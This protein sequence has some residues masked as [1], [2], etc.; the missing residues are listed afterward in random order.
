MMDAMGNHHRD[1]RGQSVEALLEV[2]PHGRHL[3]EAASAMSCRMSSSR[4]LLVYIIAHKIIHKHT[5]TN[6]ALHQ[7]V[8]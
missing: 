3:V 6:V 5:D 2:R 1:L 4:W 7:K 8:I